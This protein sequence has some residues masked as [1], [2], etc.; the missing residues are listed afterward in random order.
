MKVAPDTTGVAADRGLGQYVYLVRRTSTE[1]T[2]GG[3][4]KVIAETQFSMIAGQRRET[5][6]CAESAA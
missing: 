1:L 3:G 4:C 5:E 6:G 2:A